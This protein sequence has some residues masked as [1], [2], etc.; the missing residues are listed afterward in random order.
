[1][2]KKPLELLTV[3]ENVAHKQ[4]YGGCQQKSQI[5]GESKFQMRD[6]LAE[7]Q[8]VK[9]IAGYQHS[10]CNDLNDIDRDAKDQGVL[11]KLFQIECKV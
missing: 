9:I 8:Q 6:L 3:A 1:M 11:C 4:K 5:E 10:V 2:P 7:K